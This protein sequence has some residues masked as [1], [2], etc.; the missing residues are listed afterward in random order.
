M[1]HISKV[2]ARPE[3]VQLTGDVIDAAWP[4]IEPFLQKGIDRV[5]TRWTTAEYREGAKDGHLHLWIVHESGEPRQIL[6]VG[7]V[8][9]Y[10]TNKGLIAKVVGFGG[11]HL[12]RWYAPTLVTFE[13][14]AKEHGV[15]S[16]EIEG[17]LGWA[18]SLP[19]F[20]PARVVMEKVLSDA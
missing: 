19:G 12:R 17:R 4:L 14:M 1:S 13:A 18:R 9:F 16:I 8:Q 2:F 3:L 11:K 20:K 15:Y 7:I 6:G 10:R 5:A